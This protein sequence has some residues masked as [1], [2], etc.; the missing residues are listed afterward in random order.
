MSPLEVAERAAS[1]VI[2]QAI[3]EGGGYKW[4][5]QSSYGL[6]A[7]ETQ[8]LWGS[9]GVGLFFLKLYERTGNST[10]LDY[11]KGAAQWLIT[12]AVKDSGGYKWAHIDDD[13]P[14]PGWWLT[15]MVSG[16]G[17]FLVN[18][19][20]TTGNSTYLDYA[21]GA[22]RW[23]IAMPASE[24]GGYFVPYNPP[25]KYGSQASFGIMPGREAH[26]VAFL[27]HLYQETSNPTYL[28]Y[29]KAM[30][31]WLISGPDVREEN[32][33]YKWAHDRP[34]YYPQ[35]FISY[36]YGGGTVEVATFFYDAYQALGNTTYLQYANGALQWVL[37][38]A[39]TVDSDKVKWP[40]LQGGSDYQVVTGDPPNYNSFA[41]VSDALLKGFL[42]THNST[43]LDY[44]EKQANWIATQTPLDNA[45]RNAELF[46]FFIDMYNIAGDN[47]YSQSADTLLSWIISNAAI[48]DGGFGWK[49]LDYYAG[50]PAWFSPGASGIGYNLI[51]SLPPSVLYQLTVTSSP[52]TG[53]PFTINTVSKTTPYAESLL[54]GYY[55][56]EMPQ[57]FDGYKW[58]R[59]LEDGDTNRIK[60]IYLHGTTWTGVYT[61]PVGG[62]WTPINTTQI[63]TSWIALVFLAIAFAAAGSHR[64]LKKRW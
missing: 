53:V 32:G 37:S 42:A 59:W 24:S 60:T 49:T 6:I 23:M 27:L 3:A 20:Q 63:V 12:Q 21:E 31:D 46:R 17:G 10:Y 44:A 29:V 58:S 57:T 39:V 9:A 64:L 35:Y 15:S 2:S 13:N 4:R 45:Y 38:Q 11:A 1:Y 22:A 30:A 7:Y 28:F 8:V 55:T 47:R 56:L 16:I 52:I 62:E 61:V 14:S 54:E 5:F 43:Y 48:S 18:M 40:V 19:Y 26:T 25:G 36:G 50:Y 34:Y 33:G 41:V 51:S